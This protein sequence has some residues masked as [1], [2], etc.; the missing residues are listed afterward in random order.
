[1]LLNEATDLHRLLSSCPRSA[2]HSLP[3]S[4]ISTDFGSWQLVT[5]SGSIQEQTDSSLPCS[6]PDELPNS[7]LLVTL[8]ERESRLEEVR[9]TFL[10]AYN[11]TVALKTVS[12]SPSGAIGG[13]LEQFAR[14]VGLRG[15]SVL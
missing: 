8:T 11:S 9:S 14:G 12:P 4:S 13:L 5:G 1:M 10:A 2:D 3:G 7:A 15:S 6:F